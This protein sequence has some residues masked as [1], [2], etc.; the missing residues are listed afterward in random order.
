VAAEEA[1]AA[2]A[3]PSLAQEEEA[4]AAA[5]QRRTS[6]QLLLEL[7]VEEAPLLPRW[8]RLHREEEEELHSH[9]RDVLGRPLDGVSALAAAAYEKVRLET[10]AG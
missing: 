7:L 4:A 5:V 9:G 1:A 10:S 6:A 2:D 3:I 8:L